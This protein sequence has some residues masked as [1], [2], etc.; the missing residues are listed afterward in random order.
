[1]IFLFGSQ[2]FEG[3]LAIQERR[4]EDLKSKG[5]PVGNVLRQ[6]IAAVC[7]EEVRVIVFTCDV[8]VS[9]FSF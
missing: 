5:K 4:L 7:A 3:K 9:H 8:L 6:V 1:M 2:V